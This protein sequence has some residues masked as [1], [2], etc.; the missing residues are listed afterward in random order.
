[1]NDTGLGGSVDDCEKHQPLLLG[2]LPVP[3]EGGW[4]LCPEREGFWVTEKGRG[5]VEEP[6]I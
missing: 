2:V 3:S 6:L 4:G 5:F 1:M